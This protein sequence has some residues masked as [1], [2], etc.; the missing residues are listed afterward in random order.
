MLSD[1]SDSGS[2][3]VIGYSLTFWQLSGTVSSRYGSDL[4]LTPG[5][6]FGRTHRWTSALL[7]LWSTH[8][9]TVVGLHGIQHVTHGPWP[10]Q[11]DGE[12]KSSPARL[13]PSVFRADSYPQDIMQKNLVAE[14]PISIH[15]PIAKVWDALVNPETIKQYMFG[16]DVVSGWK[17]GDPI[18]W[19]GTWEGKK[20]EDKG[21]IL[22]L[23]PGRTLQYSHFSPMSGLPDTPQNYHTVT[24]QLTGEGNQTLVSL[25]QDKNSTEKEREHS[26]K[27][28]GM[29]LSS[30]KKLLEDGSRKKGETDAGHV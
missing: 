21:V 20:Y 26:E 15:A 19:K 7:S 12:K 5:C 13:Q 2:L 17:E 30:M 29:M 6:E 8:I 14:T 24:I 9:S 22:K 10:A 28:W 23:E 25:S 27:Q 18:V 1:L 16:T 4:S 11:E 3:S